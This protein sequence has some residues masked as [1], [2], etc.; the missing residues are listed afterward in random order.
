MPRIELSKPKKFLLHFLK[1]YLI[2]LIILLF[3]KFIK[4]AF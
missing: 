2:I 4:V 3:I 1:I